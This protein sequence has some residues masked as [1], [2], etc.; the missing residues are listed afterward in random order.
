LKKNGA[1]I[2]PVTGHRSMPPADPIPAEQMAAF[3]TAR[4][5]AMTAL[6]RPNLPVANS[7]AVAQ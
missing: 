2:N 6:S 7:N 3:E 4:E 1:F 5:Q